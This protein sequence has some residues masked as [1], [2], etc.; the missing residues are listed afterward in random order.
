[1]TKRSFGILPSGKE[2][3]LYTIQNNRITACISDFGATLVNLWVPD[4]AGNLADVVLGHDCVA[5]YVGDATC[6]GATVGRN[7]NRIGDASFS[8]GDQTYQLIANDGKNSLHSLPDGYNQRLWVVSEHRHNQIQFT[9]ESP[10]LDQG[11]PGNATVRVTYTIEPPATLCITYDAICDRDTLFNLTNHS[12]FNLA[13]HD[14]FGAA[15]DQVL[16]LPAKTFV[17]SNAQSI[18]LGEER[19]VENTPMDFRTGKP[20][21]RDIGADYECL[22][23]QGGYDHTFEVTEL[24]CAILSDPLSGRTMA[25]STDCPGVHLYSGNYMDNEPGKGNIRYPGRSGICLETHFYPDAVHNPGWKQ[26]I[27]LAGTTYHSQTR[28]IF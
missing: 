21:S 5:D 28:Y 15:I 7:A 2:A 10:H 11:F 25:I 9:L 22:K 17:P 4:K 20:V 26:P 18:P 8:I 24:P 12:F 6:M 14:R 3:S 23:L 27:V 16:T 13:G 19:S 1:M